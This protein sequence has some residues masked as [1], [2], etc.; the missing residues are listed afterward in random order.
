MGA[1][2]TLTSPKKESGTTTPHVNVS[3]G[4]RITR[5]SLGDYIA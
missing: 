3:L 2:A 1:Q 4:S 5:G